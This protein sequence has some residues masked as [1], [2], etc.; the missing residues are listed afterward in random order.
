MKI[1][2]SPTWLPVGASFQKSPPQAIAVVSNERAVRKKKSSTLKNI[3]FGNNA[4][5]SFPKS[6][7]VFVL[8]SIFRTP[9]HPPRHAHLCG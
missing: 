6:R 3:S 5:Q 9:R 2:C 7:H 1:P 4:Y 8:L